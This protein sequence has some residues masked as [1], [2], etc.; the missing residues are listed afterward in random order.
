MTK[1]ELID[2][3]REKADLGTKKD[4]E[5]ALDAILENVTAALQGGGKISLVGFGSFSVSQRKARTGRN[6]RTGAAIEIPA[7]K[8]VKFSAGKGLKDAVN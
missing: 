1:A 5:K 2:A 7:C 6:P 3:I 4:A 8:V